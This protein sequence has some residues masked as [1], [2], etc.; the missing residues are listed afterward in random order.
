MN[1][2][3]WI[4]VILWGIFMT[5][6]GLVSVSTVPDVPGAMPDQAVVMLVS[7]GLLTCLIGALGV[8]GLLSWIPGLRE[9]QKSAG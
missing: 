5:G 2:M 1:G 3:G 7:V 8:C 9:E 4:G 6:I